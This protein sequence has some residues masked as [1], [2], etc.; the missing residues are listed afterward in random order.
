M[1]RIRCSF[2]VAR[3]HPGTESRAL[4]FVLPLG[5]REEATFPFVL[6]GHHTDRQASSDTR[7]RSV[8]RAYVDCCFCFLHSACRFFL[9]RPKNNIGTG[10]AKGFW[11]NRCCTTGLRVYISFIHLDVFLLPS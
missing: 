1:M 4:G 5:L 9:A 11:A 3:R 6:L 7:S 2:S 10:R 8:L